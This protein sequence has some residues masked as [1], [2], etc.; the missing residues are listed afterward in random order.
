MIMNNRTTQMVNNAL[1]HYAAGEE[2]KTYEII[3]QLINEDLIFDIKY[4]KYHAGVAMPMANII[5]SFQKTIYNLVALELMGDENYDKLIKE[6]EPH[7]EVPFFIE[8]N[9]TRAK[10]DVA[11]ALKEINRV[12]EK[13]P[14][15]LKIAAISTIAITIISITVNFHFDIEINFDVDVNFE[16]NVGS[17][18]EGNIDKSSCS[19]V[20]NEICNKNKNIWKIMKTHHAVLSDSLP[21]LGE[22]VEINSATLSF[23]KTKIVTSPQFLVHF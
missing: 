14:K 22:K 20:L 18:Q 4:S 8:E 23:R 19:L 21:K 7:L 10:V 17:K 1:K 3:Q 6:L 5:S 16:I 13:L 12:F 2:H 15:E 11:K 9:C